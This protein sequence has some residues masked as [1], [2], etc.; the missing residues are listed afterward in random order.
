MFGAPSAAARAA[1]SHWFGDDNANVFDRRILLISPLMVFASRSALPDL[2]PNLRIR[3][4]G[5]QLVDLT[6]GDLLVLPQ[7]PNDE[8]SLRRRVSLPR[9]SISEFA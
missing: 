5:S 4:P 2:Q 1:G 6:V 7:L 9:K 3:D 8:I